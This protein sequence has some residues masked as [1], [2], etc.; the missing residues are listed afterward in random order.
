M[1]IHNF[2]VVDGFLLSV[3]KSG[4][5]RALGDIGNID[6]L[7]GVDGGKI[8]R[9]ITRNFRAQLLENAQVAAAA[10]KKVSFFSPFDKFFKPRD[11]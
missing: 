3:Q 4:D 8:N 1:R 2:V 9:P 10:N 7:L 11:S 5:R 6:S